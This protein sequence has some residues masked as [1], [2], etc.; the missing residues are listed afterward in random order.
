M[1]NDAEFAQK[2]ARRG[3]VTERRKWV[4]LPV[5]LLGF[6]VM[7]LNWFSIAVAFPQIGAE[8]DLGVSE[9]A[10]LISVFLVG[11]GLF[12]IPSGLLATRFGLR[13]VLVL[14]LAIESVAAIL[15]AMAA[16]YVQ[17]LL[18][19]FVAGIGTSIFIAIGIAAVSVWYREKYLALALGLLSAGYSVGTA[20]GLYTWAEVAEGMGWRNA[21][22]VGGGLGVLATVLI[23]AVYKTP[24]GND[25]LD[26]ER[27]TIAAVRHTLGNR[28][29]W[30]YGFAFLG[31]YGAFFAASQMLGEYGASTGALT[32][33]QVGIAVLMLGLAGIPGSVVGGWLSD[34]LS[35][36]RTFIV[37]AVLLQGLLLLALPITPPS[38]VWL[39]AAGIGFAFNGGWAVW[40]CVPG[41]SSGVRAEDIGTAIGLMLSITAVGGFLI[42][43]GFGHI[44]ETFGYSWAWVFLGGVGIVSGV[45]ALIAREPSRIEHVAVA[46]RRGAA[47][48][49]LR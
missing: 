23:A 3:P 47:G 44:V 34:R 8:F 14:G 11:V 30:L 20:L 9:L 29:L 28:Q 4:I 36:R 13:V 16:D 21:L 45:T 19:R 49:L 43:W 2:T 7:A 40:Q 42:P 15:S 46:S 22:A 17:L 32:S 25:G 33:D 6:V 18:V 26:G 5:V 27:I 39:S 35:K 1:A 37:G 12:H 10:L 41:S 48:P 24:P 31:T 38:L